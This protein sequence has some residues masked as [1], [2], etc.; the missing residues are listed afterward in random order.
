MRLAE[1]PVTGAYVD[2]I[3]FPVPAELAFVVLSPSTELLTKESRGA[4]PASIPYFDAVRSINGA[5]YLVAAFATGDFARL[6]HA[7]GDYM[8]EPYRLPK[9]PGGREAIAA[10]IAAGA[11]TGWLSG[12]GSSVL[13]V[14]E[15]GV[16]QDVL[17]AMSREFAGVGTAP[18]GRILPADNDGLAVE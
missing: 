8:H 10:G 3:R 9:I 6:G 16:A 4:L 15:H 18:E 14:C 1:R 2:T 7:T 13:C 17:A 12:S 5:A 11:F